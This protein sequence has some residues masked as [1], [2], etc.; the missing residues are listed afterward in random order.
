MNPS[1]TIKISIVGQEG[2]EYLRDPKK[3]VSATVCAGK[4]PAAAAEAA[5]AA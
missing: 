2:M 1:I 4:M 3:T 5:R